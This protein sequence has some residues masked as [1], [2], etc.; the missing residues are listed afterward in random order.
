[1]LVSLAAV[2]STSFADVAGLDDCNVISCEVDN[3][4][5]SVGIGG[6]GWN[7][8][9]NEPS[10]PTAGTEPDGPPEPGPSTPSCTVENFRDTACVV[11]VL[12]DYPDTIYNTDLIHF[13]PHA[14]SA[15]TANEGMTL[16]TSPASVS[17]AA[18]AH[19]LT[20]TLLGYSVTVTFTPV[21]V[22]IEFGDG[23]SAAHTGASAVFDHTYP[24]R[25]TYATT[26]IAEYTA[27]VTFSDGTPRPVIG[28]ITSRS[29]GPDIRVLAAR[30]ALTHDT[31]ITTPRAPGC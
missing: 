12:P 4:G 8:I 10:D 5:G 19:I 30:T 15:S 14:A 25:G 24:A 1:M 17:V 23:S 31:C 28:T 22:G 13:T 7:P 16:V 26:L 27:T 2:S 11:V 6:S 9:T 20:G 21:Q 29:P 18:D 3:D